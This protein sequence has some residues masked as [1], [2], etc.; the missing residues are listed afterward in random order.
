MLASSSSKN[1][2]NFCHSV[3]FEGGLPLKGRKT[4]AVTRRAKRK[5]ERRVNLNAWQSFFPEEG[6]FP[7][8]SW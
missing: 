1:H 4:P 7:S 3:E 6:S 5:Q 8:S 2:S